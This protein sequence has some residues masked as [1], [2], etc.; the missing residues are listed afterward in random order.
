MS[1]LVMRHNQRLGDSSV[2]AATLKF[3]TVTLAFGEKVWYN[4]SLQIYNI[5][6][7]LLMKETKS[8]CPAS[9]SL[10]GYQ[11]IRGNIDPRWFLSLILIVWWSGEPRINCI[12]QMNNGKASVNSKPDPMIL[13][14][15]N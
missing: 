11:F 12:V 3:L 1:E 8:W 9:Y 14:S 15:D 13:R 4:C 5:C 10:I 2:F 6:D 7:L